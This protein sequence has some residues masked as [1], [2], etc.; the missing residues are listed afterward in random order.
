MAERGFLSRWSRL[1]QAAEKVSSAE[2][3][4]AESLLANLTAESD[5][6]QFLREEVSEEI[7]RKAMKTLFA[8][9]SFNV[10]DSMDIYIDDY[11]IFEP[12]PPEMMA[13]LKQAKVLFETPESEAE[14]VASEHLAEPV[15][16]DILTIDGQ[17]VPPAIDSAL[18]STEN[19]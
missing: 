7:R 3:T 1:K 6:G 8:D 19:Q 15:D 5:F 13:T 16:C 9:P 14:P 11:T 18:P 12:I 17:N 10:I 2:V 4:D